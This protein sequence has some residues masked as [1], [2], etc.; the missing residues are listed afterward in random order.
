MRR[1][2]GCDTVD[3]QMDGP[4]NRVRMALAFGAAAVALVT[5]AGCGGVSQP[6][7]PAGGTAVVGTA[8]RLLFAGDVMLGRG[9][10]DLDAATVFTDVRFEV[11]SADLSVANLESPLT[12]R[13]HDP[14][15]GPNALEA[16]PF[17]ARLLAAA[18]FDAVGVANNHAGDAGPAT[19]GDT[20]DAL[21]AA[22]LEAIGAGTSVDEAYEP[23]SVEIGGVRVALL[24]FDATGA[25]P[26]VGAGAP[27][28][29]WWD[30]ARAREAVGHARAI[31]DVVAVGIHGGTEYVPGTDPYLM[32]LAQ[33]LAG[34]GADV[35]WG[36]GPHVVQPVH[37]LD[38][39]GDGRATVVT[40][41]L[42]NLIFDQHLPGTRR[43]AVL[44]VLAGSDGIRVWRAGSTDHEDGPVRFAGWETPPGDAVLLDG[45]WWALARPADP[46]VAADP[47]PLAGFAGD[48]VDA[49][50]G[51][52]DEDGEPDL[53]V[54]FR[55]PYSPTGVNAL[56][57]RETLVDARGRTA[58]LGLY[59]PDDLRPRWV[60]GT[61]V[62]PVSAVAACDGMLA[63]AYSKL[64]DPTVVSTG[65]WRWGGFGFLTLPDLPGTGSPAC[66]DV[67][68]DGRLDPLV[69]ERSSR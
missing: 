69:L 53:V 21:A 57:P 55:R 47:G 40:T 67:D 62:R 10:A 11:A 32:R 35:V 63:L 68:G 22:G 64:D 34:W 19:V 8:V 13:P 46:V 4:A 37:V 14:G 42:G 2:P 29:A 56:L 26:R 15:S 28:V 3:G 7:E 12:N 1:G 24:A 60:A 6:V 23:R 30:E 39:D 54:A 18:G 25:G 52:A 31:A 5:A 59:R 41:S 66:A 38:P 49:T 48:V 65:A 27:G 45:G 61:L 44:E 20:V 51:D 50:L 36:T 33:Q 43:G 9:V 17:S 58:H 16:T